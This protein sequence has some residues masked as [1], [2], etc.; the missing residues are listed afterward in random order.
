MNIEEFLEKIRLIDWFGRIGNDLDHS[1]R[2]LS[3]DEWVG[4]E[5]ISCSPMGLLI[6]EIKESLLD[7]AAERD[8]PIEPLMEKVQTE[9]L[10]EAKKYVPYDE[11][12]DAWYAPNTAVWQASWIGALMYISSVL[13]LKVHKDIERQW[14]WFSDGHWPC[15]YVLKTEN[16]QEMFLRWYSEGGPVEG[17]SDYFEKNYYDY[18]VY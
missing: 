10:V 6:N 2:I 9:I 18:V 14:K 7:V 12:E 5:D 15:T 4:P 17:F 16:D 11:N 1:H 3:W 13:E 8:L